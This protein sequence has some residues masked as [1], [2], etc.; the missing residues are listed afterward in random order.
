ME[1][2]LHFISRLFIIKSLKKFIL[3]FSRAHWCPPCRHFTP[4]LAEIFK[5]VDNEIK[6]KLDIVFISCDEDQAAFDG[7]FKEMPWKALPFSGMFNVS[8]HIK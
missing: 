4:K 3:I 2:L 6:E 5:G 1:K 8:L 7:Y